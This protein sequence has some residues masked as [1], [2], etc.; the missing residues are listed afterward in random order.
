MT[1][2]L[3][4]AA[5]LPVAGLGVL[6]W[7]TGAGGSGSPGSAVDMVVLFGLILAGFAGAALAVGLETIL[8]APLQRV[9]EGAKRIAEGDRRSLIDAPGEDE[10]AQL[11]D[12]YNRL[13]AELTHRDQ[14][15]AAVRQAIAGLA[16]EEAARGPDGERR[17]ADAAAAGAKTA[18]DTTDARLVVGD[19]AATPA[20]ERIPGDP[21]EV[22]AAVAAGGRRLGVLIGTLPPARTWTSTEQDLFDLYAATL[23]MIRTYQ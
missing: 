1:V 12:R 14:R 21:Y 11:A 4:A 23:V 10:L 3:V 22:R 5:V 16:T 7:A 17:F 19:A 9:L 20:P 6:M 8:L 15:L 13:A 18:F 2:A